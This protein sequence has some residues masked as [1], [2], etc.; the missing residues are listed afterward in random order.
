VYERL[1]FSLHGYDIADIH[2]FWLWVVG[3]WLWV[4][5]FLLWVI[6]CWLWF[7]GCGFC[8]LSAGNVADMGAW[9]VSFFGYDA[10]CR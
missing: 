10:S 6:G 1:S 3:F 7:V 9:R 5:V 8:G 4:I 2:F